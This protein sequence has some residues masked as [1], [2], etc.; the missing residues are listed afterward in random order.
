MNHKILKILI[1]S[2]FICNYVNAQDVGAREEA[3]AQRSLK[4]SE[5]SAENASFT[6]LYQGSTGD[7]FDSKT[8]QLLLLGSNFRIY[9]GSSGDGFSQK[10]A[11]TTISGNNLAN[12]YG[13]NF[14]DGFSQ[15]YFQS[16]LNGQELSM[17]FTGNIGDGADS[18]ALSGSYLQGFLNDILFHGGNG[19]GFATLL[20][21]NNYITGLMLM[22]YNGGNCDGFAVNKLTSALTL[23]VID[24]L[25]K[26]DVLIYPNP[27]NNIV[28]I[29]AKNS[30]PIKSVQLFDITGKE[31]SSIKL[32]DQNTINVSNLSDGIYLLNIKSDDGSIT[33][34]LIVKK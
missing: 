30:N 5:L 20:S 3:S 15:D 21:S 17:I 12:L 10:L 33:K 22:L 7:G 29:I 31:M 32:S 18:I 24:L 25:I 19:D 23:E 8:N 28:N 6:V 2:I 13:G 11:A 9:G 4:S 34:K 27:A 26:M 1:S 16:L 14:G